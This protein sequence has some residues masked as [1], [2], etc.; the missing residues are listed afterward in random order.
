MSNIIKVGVWIKAV[1]S[2]EN[3]IFRLES[4]LNEP[5]YVNKKPEGDVRETIFKLKNLLK[6]LKP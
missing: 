4:T 2:V 3:V 6:K 5:S 1:K